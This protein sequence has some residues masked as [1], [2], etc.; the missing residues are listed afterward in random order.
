MA[1]HALSRGLGDGWLWK[2]TVFA[3]LL[4]G[5]ALGMSVFAGIGFSTGSGLAHIREA[6]AKT[7][8]G[9]ERAFFVLASALILPLWIFAGYQV[10]H[11]MLWQEIIATDRHAG[12][13]WAPL[14][15]EPMLFLLALAIFTISFAALPPLWM[16]AART[17]FA[18]PTRA[19]T[20]LG[21]ARGPHA[22][23][24]W[25]ERRGTPRIGKGA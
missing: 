14:Q 5:F 9:M 17:T 3:M 18:R 20:A 23:Y 4:A 19:G 12:S 25:R 21:M 1:I 6:S 13:R 8:K 16:Q 24:R 7:A 22:S 10:L 2:S 11:A 15:D